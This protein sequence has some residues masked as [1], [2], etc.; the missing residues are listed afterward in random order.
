MVQRPDSARWWVL[1]V[2]CL[3]LLVVGLDITILNVAL[4]TISSSLGASTAELQWIVDSYT[5]AFAAVMLPA[6]VLG[7]RYGRKKV[8]LLGLATFTVASVW[9]ALAGSSTELIVA[10]TL[11]GAGAAVVLPLTLAFV[12]DTFDDRERP[13][14]IAIITTAFAAG[15]PLGPIIGGFLVQHFYWG[16][17]F[18]INVPVVAVAVV[19][20]WML[21]R[22]SRSPAPPP[23]DVVGLILVIASVV[24]LVWGFITAPEEGWGAALTI[25]LL[26]GSVLLLLAFF[27]W[28]ART[29]DRI[30]DPA[31]FRKP[32][33]TWGTIAAVVVSIALFAVLFV[34]PLFLQ[35]VS[36]NDAF[37]TGIR[38]VPLMGGLMVTGALAGFVDRKIGT[39][40]T[41]VA[42]LVLLA[43][44]LVLLS[45]VE[46][47]SGYGVVAV[48]LA[49]CGLGVGA[50][51][52]PA[53]E[54]VTAEVGDESGAGA[55]VANTL[56]QVGGALAVAVL[57]SMLSTVYANRLSEASESLPDGTVETASESVMNAAAIADEL[58]PA[59]EALSTA[60]GEAFATAMSGVM[61]S[62]A[63]VV[64]IGALLCGIFLPA[65]A[66]GTTE[67][68]AV[69]AG[70][71]DLVDVE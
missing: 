38:L 21:L 19:A 70:S 36:G 4:P 12:A 59:G 13:K 62:C 9:S 52:A 8:L 14:A 27:V 7:D 5:L 58:G 55:A 3:A 1:G 64:L 56:R 2:L 37:D 16:S 51:M 67:G 18:W 40:I 60:A 66:G 71:E 61:I 41:V 53:M 24:A 23:M 44:G 63:V 33:F 25:C 11:L 48:A 10:R 6:G 43:V 50:A 17:V 68:S 32:R 30:V 46:A 15:L 29:G 54:A 47:D 20:G 65:R 26:G 42:G 45:R 22:E 31:L 34:V 39:K 49:L 35:G 69:K 28:E 57:G